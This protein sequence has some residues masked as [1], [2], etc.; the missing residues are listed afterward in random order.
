[1]KWNFGRLIIWVSFLVADEV[2]KFSRFAFD[3]ME[4]S[5]QVANV[6]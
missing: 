3:P 5:K 6:K 2:E 1:L 4:L